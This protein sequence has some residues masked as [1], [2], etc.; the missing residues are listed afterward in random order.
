MISID[1]VSKSYG[2]SL[3]LDDITVDLPAGGVTCLIGP[4]GAG[5]STLLSIIARLL[6][7]DAGTVTVGGLDV[8]RTDTRELARTMAVLRQDN[9]LTVRLTVRDLVSFGRFPHNGGR[10][11]EADHRA[12]E[13]AIEWMDLEAL[14][15]APYV[16]VEPAEVPSRGGA[17]TAGG[18]D[19]PEDHGHR[20]HPEHPRHHTPAPGGPQRETQARHHRTEEGPPDHRS[21]SSTPSRTSPTPRAP[22]RTQDQ[23]RHHP[24][25]RPDRHHLAQ[26][27]QRQPRPT[28]TDPPHDH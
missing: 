17:R 16:T 21:P 27:H 1:Q 3:V 26:P 10:P 24:H 19:H 6:G 11:T 4:N 25:H 14:A 18:R 20:D 12:V 13:K 15:T 23:R 22:Q 2:S 28:P 9:Q 7:A 8:S 5:K